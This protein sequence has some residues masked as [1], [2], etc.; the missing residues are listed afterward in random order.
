VIHVP[1]KKMRR[2]LATVC[3]LI[4]ALDILT[5]WYAL[6]LGASEGNPV[7][8]RLF[9]LHGFW[10]AVALWMPLDFI[11]IAFVTAY[12]F[13]ARRD[14]RARVLGLELSVPAIRILSIAAITTFAF[15]A[16]IVLHNGIVI[17]QMLGG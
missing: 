4:L 11:R 7:Q 13:R 8:A 6:R 2:A 9:E 10:L 17:D 1:N 14:Q 5:T 16:V 3:L 12:P 15:H